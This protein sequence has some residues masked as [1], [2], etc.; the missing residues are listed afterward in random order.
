MQSR[1]YLAKGKY[2]YGYYRCRKY[3]QHGDAGCDH[4]KSHRADKIETAV[5][6]FVSGLLQQLERLQ[7]GLDEM[8][9]QERAAMRGDPEQV[10]KAWLDKL[11]EVDQERRGYL[12][13]AAKG[14]M[15]DDELDEA[16]GEL[17][18][19]RKAAER[20]LRAIQGQREIIE[21]LERDRDTIL[22]YYAGMVPEALDELTGEERHRVYRMLRLEVYVQPNGDLETRGVIRTE[23]RGATIMYL[24][25]CT[26]EATPIHC[27]TDAKHPELQFRARL[28]DG[29]PDLELALV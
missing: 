9:E 8:I 5:W 23:V 25:F 21:Q 11:A 28:S 10:V 7:Q 3:H 22:E 18:D 14:H 24:E 4:R 6:E 1:H 27:P 12:R 17:E 15:S 16:L 26:T 13:L 2:Q 20:E 19:T 29:A